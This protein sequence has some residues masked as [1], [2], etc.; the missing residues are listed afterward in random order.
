MVVGRDG[1]GEPCGSVIRYGPLRWR[2]DAWPDRLRDVRPAPAAG[3]VVTLCDG[4]VRLLEPIDA[5]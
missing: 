3:V 5:A 1:H 2:V 4:T